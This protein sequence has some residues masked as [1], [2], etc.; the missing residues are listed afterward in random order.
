MQFVQKRS[1]FKFADKESV[2]VKKMN[3]IKMKL[4]TCT[5]TTGKMTG[6]HLKNWPGPINPS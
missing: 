4:T 2:V 3:A 6:G 1:I 5:R